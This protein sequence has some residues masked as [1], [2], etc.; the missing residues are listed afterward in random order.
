MQ[1]RPR[2]LSSLLL[3]TIGVGFAFA[4][5]SGDQDEQ[6][7]ETIDE[8]YTAF[9]DAENKR[10]NKGLTGAWQLISLETPDE[11]VDSQDFR[12][13]ALFHD[14]YMT[15]LLMGAEDEAAIFAIDTIYTILTGAYRYQVG[16]DLT[17][18]LASVMGIDNASGN[19]LFNPAGEPREFE[20]LLVEDDLTLWEIAGNHYEFR[21]LGPTKF[22]FGAADR[23]RERRTSW[24][25]EDDYDEGR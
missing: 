15:L 21:R 1:L 17:L 25:D 3:T 13:F 22:P 10:L 24:F 23:L 18:Q 8:P 5:E 20:M 9:L 4:Q 11:F 14:G 6:D 16:E 12:G 7:Q 2:L 19:F